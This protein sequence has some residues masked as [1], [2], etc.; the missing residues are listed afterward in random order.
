MLR[1]ISPFAPPAAASLPLD[2]KAM[3]KTTINKIYFARHVHDWTIKT[4]SG[5]FIKYLYEQKAIAVQ[6]NRVESWDQQDYRGSKNQ[7]PSAIKY[8]NECSAD[9]KKR[10]IFASY[11]IQNDHKVI[12]G[13]P[14]KNSKCFLREHLGVKEELPIK[15]LFLEPNSNDVLQSQFPFAYLLAP[16][17]STF[18]RW[19]QCEKIANSFIEGSAYNPIEPDSYLPWALEVICEEYLR[20]RGLLQFKLYKCGGSLKDFDI[21]GLDQHGGRVVAQ[22]KNRSTQGEIDRF[23]S[24][25]NEL[26]AGSYYF[27]AGNICNEDRWPNINLVSIQDVLREFQ[28]CGDYLQ[29]L[30]EAST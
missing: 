6:F 26:G 14:K 23:S 22:V 21:V 1:L 16:K 7:G 17:Q 3:H 20:K 9:N 8:I 10:Y 4:M 24:S 15:L 28:A 27:F 19:S 18:V 29:K 5:S 12:M 11:K 13:R 2:R 25:S 30:M